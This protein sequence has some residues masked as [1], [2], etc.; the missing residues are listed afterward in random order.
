[1]SAYIRHLGYQENDD[2]LRRLNN[3]DDIDD[4]F[5]PL[6]RFYMS[7]AI[8]WAGNIRPEEILVRT[9]TDPHSLG[10]Y[11][12]N[13]TLSNIDSFYEAFGVDTDWNLYRPESERTVIW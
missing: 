3:A 12:V 11:R 13:A 5:T 6:Q 4:G 9:Q 1:M 7:Y 2:V 10:R 8:L